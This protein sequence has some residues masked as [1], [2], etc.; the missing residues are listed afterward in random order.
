MDKHMYPVIAG[1]GPAGCSIPV[2]WMIIEVHGNLFYVKEK[3][4]SLEY[5]R[6]LKAY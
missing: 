6:T 1:K 5:L 4:P 2:G 3:I